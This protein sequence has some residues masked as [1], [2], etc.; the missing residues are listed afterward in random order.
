LPACTPDGKWV[1]YADNSFRAK[2]AIY[3][4]AAEGGAAQKI[5]EGSVW[6]A[7][8]HKGDKVAWITNEGHA[9]SLVQ[10]EIATGRELARTPIASQLHITRSL[11]YGSDD[12][13]I[14]LISRG[15]TSDSVY[16]MKLDGSAPVKQIEFRGAHLAA[17]AVSP[18]GTHL[19]VVK[20]KP[21]SDAVLLQRT[22]P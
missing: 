20:V 17:I 11:T 7:V 1:L 8:S 12:Q 16:E 14:L 5:G 2:A 13:R 3:R 18:S 15:E 21:V 9:L 19:G 4:V 22:N 10:A 6:F